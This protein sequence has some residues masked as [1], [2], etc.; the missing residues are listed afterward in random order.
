MVFFAVLICRTI[1]YGDDTGAIPVPLQGISA[2]M[3]MK[4][5]IDNWGFPAKRDFKNKGEV[6]FY[7]N[8]NTPSP[9][10]GIV[11]HFI[12]KKVERWSLVDNIY[13]EMNIWGKGAGVAR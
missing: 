12:K 8:E 10:D 6:W 4:H 2:G 13:A 9:T 11:V 3:K 1:V 5:L 7:L